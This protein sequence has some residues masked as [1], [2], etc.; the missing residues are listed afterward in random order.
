MHP[1]PP[2]ICARYLRITAPPH[3]TISL[4]E[5]K[6]YT[7]VEPTKTKAGYQAPL[8]ATSITS[9]SI[10]SSS[11]ITISDRNFPAKN[12]IDDYPS[13]Y[14]ETSLAQPTY[15]KNREETDQTKCRERDRYA[16]ATTGGSDCCGKEITSA[17]ADGYI[18]MPLLTHTPACPND[19]SVDYLC[20]APDLEVEA[21]W[22]LVDYGDI[23]SFS[24]ARCSFF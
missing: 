18:P 7:T 23:V 13:T 20:T 6:A 17:C 1:Q 8:R 10:I 12:C 2:G 15:G 16:N 22:L 11:E 9:S 21:S 19:G 4:D 24:H 14:C 5:V 3:G